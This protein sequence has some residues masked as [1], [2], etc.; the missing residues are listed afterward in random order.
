MKGSDGRPAILTANNIVANPDFEKIRAS[1]FN[2]YYYEPF[3]ETLNR[4][5][6]HEKVISLYTEG[7]IQNLIKPQFHGREHVNVL[8]WLRALRNKDTLV[9][10]AFKHKMFSLP[11]PHPSNCRLEYL[12]ALSPESQNDIGF[13]H[14]SI[15]DG[16]NLFY[17]IWNFR[18]ETFIAPCYQWER[19][20]E[21]ILHYNGIKLI[22]G[23]NAQKTSQYGIDKGKIHRHFAGKK[24]NNNQFYSIRNVSF[25]PATNHNY[26]WITNA[27]KQISIAFIF[28]QPAIIS[29]HRLNFTGSL[30]NANR[31]SNLE[32]L[33]HLLRIVKKKWPEVEIK[34]SDELIEIYE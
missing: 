29:S 24:N 13:I 3:T 33:S 4:Y 30:N 5:P 23:G 6:G 28:H 9:S 14:D 26:D 22:Q 1:G 8:N 32:M 18:S 21:E 15:V 11:L 17:K 34:S 25:E 12:N 2:E 7:M 19:E 20:T 16:L 10:D 27:L 31:S